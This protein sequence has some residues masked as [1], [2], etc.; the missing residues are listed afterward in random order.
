M[1]KT[2]FNKVDFLKFLYNLHIFHVKVN[3]GEVRIYKP[4]AWVCGKHANNHPHS[5]IEADD[6]I[7]FDVK[8]ILLLH[9]NILQEKKTQA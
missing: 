7:K 9:P 2:N 3:F 6:Q 8:A 5:N 4:F 1:N